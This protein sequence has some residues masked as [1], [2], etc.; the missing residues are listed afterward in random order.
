MVFSASVSVS[1]FVFLCGVEFL[2]TRSAATVLDVLAEPRLATRAGALM[3]PLH[4]VFAL[5]PRA[6]FLELLLAAHTFA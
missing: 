3:C 1:A 6:K 5:A 2:P 4:W